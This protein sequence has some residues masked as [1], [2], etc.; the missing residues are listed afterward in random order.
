[1]VLQM[2]GSMVLQRIEREG[3]ANSPP[4]WFFVSLAALIGKHGFAEKLHF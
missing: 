3:K 2:R 1:M 4:F